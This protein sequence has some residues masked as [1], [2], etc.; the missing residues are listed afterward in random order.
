[1]GYR[2]YVRTLLN[3]Y[4]IRREIGKDLSYK[5]KQETRTSTIYT[6]PEGKIV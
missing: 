1:M 6:I 2:T 5:E 4:R 3:L